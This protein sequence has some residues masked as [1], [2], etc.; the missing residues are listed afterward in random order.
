MTVDI[1]LFIYFILPSYKIVS[2][3][4][5]YLENANSSKVVSWNLPQKYRR[6]YLSEL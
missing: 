6:N 5:Y 3:L 1:L 2:E 4:W